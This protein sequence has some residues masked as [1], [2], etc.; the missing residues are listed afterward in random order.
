VRAFLLLS[1]ALAACAGTAATTTGYTPVT[2]VLVRADALVS[3]IGCGTGDTQVYKYAAVVTQGATTATNTSGAPA[4]G[5]YD[6]FADAKFANLQAGPDGT[7]SF[8]VQVF[9]FDKRA[10]DAQNANGALTGDSAGWDRLQGHTPTFKTSC[11][12]TQQAGVEVLAVCA[13]LQTGGPGTIRL[14]TTGFTRG[15]GGALACGTDYK[16]VKAFFKAGEDT[17]DLAPVDCPAP[18]VFDKAKAPASYAIDVQLLDP[19]GTAGAGT[20][21]CRATT[22]PGLETKADCDPVE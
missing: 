10:F 18:I 14:E 12:A 20:A 9:A 19:T 8:T 21:R 15:D 16:S 1:A 22:T 7:L 11:S 17:G 2:G 5:V 13:P 6:C 3:G 4:G